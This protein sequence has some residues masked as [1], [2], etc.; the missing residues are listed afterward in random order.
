MAESK[1]TPPRFETLEELVEF[2]D[3]HDLGDYWDELPEAHFDVAMKRRKRLVAIEEELVG[4]VAEIARAR[5][6]STEELINAWLKEKVAQ[7]G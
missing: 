1:S 7:A 5:D 6:V 3:S 2:F 4:R